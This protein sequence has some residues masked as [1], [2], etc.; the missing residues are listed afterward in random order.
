MDNQTSVIGTNSIIINTGNNT[1]LKGAVIANSTNGKIDGDGIDGNNLIINTK[2]LTYSGIID[3]E[4]KETSGIGIALNV[5][6]GKDK[7]FP[8]QNNN[9]YPK[10]Y[11]SQSYQN[12]GYEKEQIT[13]ATIGNGQI[14]TGAASAF[15]N[16]TGDLTSS[17]G[18]TLLPTNSDQLIGLNRD[19]TKTQEITKDTITA[20]LDVSATIDLRLLSTTGRKQIVGEVKD[21][22]RNLPFVLKG[23][24]L[25]IAEPLKSLDNIPYVG[26]VLQQITSPITGT[27]YTFYENGSKLYLTSPDG[28]KMEVSRA[29]LTKYYDVNGILTSEQKAELNYLL[30]TQNEDLTIRHNPSHGFIGDLIESGIGKLVNN[31]GL[32]DLVA[33]NRFVAGDLYER[34]DIT[35][36]V[37]NFHS[38]GT[39]IG[40]GAMNIYRNDYMQPIITY[41]GTKTISYT[42]Q[43]N[44]SQTF[45][46][47]GPAVTEKG[48]KEGVGGLNLNTN[49]KIGDLNYNYQHD[50]KDFVQLIVAPNNLLEFARG[51]Y[52]VGQDIGNAIIGNTN[53]LNFNH[54]DVTNSIYL[55]FSIDKNPALVVQQNQTKGK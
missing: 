34:K 54:H 52:L 41:D 5:N 7:P 14:T 15:D 20:A 26:S 47:V 36:A 49:V 33:M 38:Q 28:T 42:N 23:N 16:N 11:L 46:A 3:T 10:G 29:D 2:T 53:D 27:V 37:N 30:K 24:A 19:I 44:P 13:K 25:M 21:L 51:W 1:N 18:G 40:V 12:S 32:E 6:F 4:K 31:T 45:N 17:T 22:P 35:G 48:W 8:N 43:I 39:I 50:P 9:Y 55:K